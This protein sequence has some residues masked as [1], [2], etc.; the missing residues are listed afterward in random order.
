M[1][2]ETKITIKRLPITKLGQLHQLF[3]AAVRTNFTYFN[4]AIQNNT[5]RSHSPLHL[6]LAVVHPRRIILTAWRGQDLI[7]Y[8]IGS[9]PKS[10]AGQLYWLYVA[11]S[12]RGS[13]TGLA[14]LSQFLRRERALGATSVTLATYDH[15]HY[16]QRQGFE[17]LGTQ[18]VDG[19]EMAI[20]KYPII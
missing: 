5:I 2:D 9:V 15:R 12:E 19:L 11:P 4:E 7:G 20:M 17:Y 6:G 3:A 14:L 18:L 16:Y 13:N 1:P 8:A 10:G